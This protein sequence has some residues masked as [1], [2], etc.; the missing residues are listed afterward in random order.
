MAHDCW[1]CIGERRHMCSYF[2]PAQGH[3]AE[4]KREVDLRFNRRCTPGLHFLVAYLLST[5]SAFKIKEH[6]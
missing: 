3:I 4:K 1:S 2:M 5:S 6:V